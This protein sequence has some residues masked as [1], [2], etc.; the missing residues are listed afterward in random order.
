MEEDKASESEAE[1]MPPT[2]ASDTDDR[3]TAAQRERDRG[4]EGGTEGGKIKKHRRDEC[5]GTNLWWGRPRMEDDCSLQAEKEG[6]K[7]GRMEG[8]PPTLTLYSVL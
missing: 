7:E 6:T 8:H 4:R 3:A 1:K 2:Q 5:S